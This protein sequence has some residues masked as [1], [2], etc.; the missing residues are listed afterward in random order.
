[1]LL[2]PGLNAQHAIGSDEMYAWH[3][4]GTTLSPGAAMQT[5]N[6]SLHTSSIQQLTI[7]HV[8]GWAPITIC[9]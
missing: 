1:V 8:I 6:T 5:A 3:N 7:K 9:H 4:K 2:F